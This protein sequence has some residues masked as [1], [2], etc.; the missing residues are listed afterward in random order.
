MPM[1][2]ANDMAKAR[3]AMAADRTLMA[4]VRTALSMISFGFTIAKFFQ[5]LEQSGRPVANPHSPRN[6]GLTL[7]ALGIAGVVA[8]I[9]E[10]QHTLRELG[11]ER[12]GARWSVT[13]ISAI[14]IALI[15][16]V[17]FVSGLTQSGP[18]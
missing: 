7:T 18:F 10:H 1:L 2:D 11:V 5:Y 8:A 3:T 9:V 17:V 13:V 14:V 16:A 6:L 12:P 4:W 15:G